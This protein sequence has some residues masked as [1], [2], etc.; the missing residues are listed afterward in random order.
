MPNDND[1]G[2]TV[3]EVNSEAYEDET[4]SENNSESH[5]D[6][7]RDEDE[8]DIDEEVELKEPLEAR[9]FS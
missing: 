2:S 4:S 8:D 5:T 7:D 9:Q 6:T 3:I 1:V